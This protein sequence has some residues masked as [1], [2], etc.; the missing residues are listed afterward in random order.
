MHGDTS[1]MLPV[2]CGCPQWCP[3]VSLL[4]PPWPVLPGLRPVE[5]GV[6]L[7]IYAWRYEPNVT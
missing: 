1:Q 2:A 3:L 4:S 6:A 5:V 7:L